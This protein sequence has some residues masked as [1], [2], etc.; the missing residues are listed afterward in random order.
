MPLVED[1]AFPF[2]DG[3]FCSFCLL[4][5][6]AFTT[7]LG[8]GFLFAFLLIA[9]LLIAFL[10]LA[11]FLL[12]RLLFYLYTSNLGDLE[13]EIA[14]KYILNCIAGLTYKQVKKKERQ[15]LNTK[16]SVLPKLQLE[17]VI[18]DRLQNKRTQHLS[19]QLLAVSHHIAFLKESCPYAE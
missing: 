18:K 7:S 6:A 5:S 9:F 10:L 1:A 8:L 2:D 14:L 15:I 13:A 3:S 19:K 11:F 17:S 4:E 12:F 16:V